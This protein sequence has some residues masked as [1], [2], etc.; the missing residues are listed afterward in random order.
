[1]REAKKYTTMMSSYSSISGNNE[2][3][4]LPVIDWITVSENIK[5]T[6]RNWSVQQCQQRYEAI[7]NTSTSLSWTGD[8][9]ILCI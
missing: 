5:K 7:R 8:E 2:T 3:D 4:C 6:G 1:M 9:V